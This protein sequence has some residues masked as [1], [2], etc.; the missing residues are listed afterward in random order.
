MKIYIYL[1][2]F[3][4]SFQPKNGSLSAWS[5]NMAF[6]PREIIAPTVALRLI[7]RGLHKSVHWASCEED[8]FGLLSIFNFI[9]NKDG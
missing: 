9:L 6:G 7:R 1:P 2:D 3:C 4:F 8:V 5:T